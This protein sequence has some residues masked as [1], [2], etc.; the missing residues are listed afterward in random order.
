L[1][2]HAEPR[3]RGAEL[4]MASIGGLAVGEREGPR[5]GQRVNA[6]QK[7]N[8]GDGLLGVHCNAVILR[9]RRGGRPR[10]CTKVIGVL[11]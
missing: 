1:L 9:Q 2:P 6:L 3:V 5:V 4:V 7:L 10:A 8:V 11:R